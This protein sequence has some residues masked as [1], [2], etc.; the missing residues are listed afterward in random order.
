[1]AAGALSAFGLTGCPLAPFG[2]GRDQHVELR[3]LV[4][5]CVDDLTFNEVPP[6]EGRAPTAAFSVTP[7][8]AEDGELV[9]L[10]AT[11][12]DPDSD[13]VKH[14][15]DVDGNGILETDTGQTAYTSH[16][17]TPGRYTLTLRVTDTDGNFDEETETLDVDPG[18]GGGVGPGNSSPTASF[19]V[20]PS[21]G[22][23]GE[24][25]HFDGSG[26]SDSDG[27]IASYQW[28]FENDGAFDTQPDPSPT[29][30][31]VY[32]APGQKTAKLRVADDRGATGETTRDFLIAEQGPGRIV[33]AAG[34]KPLRFTARLLGRPLKRHRG[35]VSRR[36]R[37]ASRRG[38]IAAGRL[39]GRAVGRDPSR[40]GRFGAASWLARLDFTSN[41]RTR[42]ASV[43]GLVLVTFDGQPGGQACV[44]ITLTARKG[45]KPRAGF[46]IVG[47]DG[48][49]AGLTGRG[50]V[51]FK[52]PR[53]LAARL[54]GSLR[55]RTGT[56]TPI[57]ARCAALGRVRP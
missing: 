31:H 30:S 50:K 27:S 40:L 38:L 10:F 28:D 34:P 33:P 44:R 11:G 21:P 1:M 14:E 6:A 39:S 16:A 23:A 48:A 56:R 37:V 41:R 46:R 42:R 18:E 55:V 49:A 35:K 5:G 12:Q 51:G 45:H 22:R 32:P 25:V 13:I 3:D 53:G 47:A 4:Y 20:T 17:Y 24:S 15:W 36:G 57:P 8:P 2:C 54:T 9:S 26:S 7:N 19:T 52:R 43:K 29:V